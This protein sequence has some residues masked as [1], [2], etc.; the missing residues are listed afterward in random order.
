[1]RAIA[2]SAPRKESWSVYLVG[3]G[4]AVEAGWRDASVD[5]DLWSDREEIFRDIQHIKERLN[6]NIELARPEH[7][8]PPLRGSADRHV[9]VERVRSVSFYHYDPYAQILAKIVR[10]F[11][12]DV[13][14]A[15]RFLESGM[16]D[17]EKLRALVHEIPDEAFA[18]YPS[19][20][21]GEL[22]GAVEDFLRS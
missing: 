21:P 20:S 8:V 11:R 7:F 14:D 15:H 17:P 1:M 19:L 10:G 4:T 5:A 22:R 9:F 18:R 6:V 2:D 13:E 12:R 16:V 3:G